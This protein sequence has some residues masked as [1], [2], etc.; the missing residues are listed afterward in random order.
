M[1]LPYHHEGAALGDA[2]GDLATTSPLSQRGARVPRYVELR[3]DL[4]VWS[5]WWDPRTERPPSD[6]VEANT[7]TTIDPEKP[8]NESGMLDAFVR[9]AD[10]SSVLRFAERYGVL[11]ICEHGLPDS[12]ALPPLPIPDRWPGCRA[13]KELDYLLYAEPVDIWLRFVAQMR[14]LLSLAVDLRAGSPGRT[15]DW[16]LAYSQLLWREEIAPLALLTAG[17]EVEQDRVMLAERI[18]TWM[19][20]GNVRPGLFWNDSLPAFDLTGHTFGMLGIQLLFAATRAQG[21][22]ICDGCGMPYARKSKPRKD[23][24]NFCSNCGE[25][26][27]ARLRKRASRNK[28][29][30]KGAERE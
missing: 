13:W 6:A 8:V 11:G 16:R 17:Q 29:E 26:V 5:H 22:S 1:T 19:Q 2:R 12:H 20:F 23:R 25:R 3:D 24:R 18:S 30:R 27:A 9:I 7:R 28:D 14:A 15:D 10:A 21:I 4:L